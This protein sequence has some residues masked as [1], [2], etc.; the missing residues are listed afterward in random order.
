MEKQERA[1][2]FHNQGYNCCQ[3]V[4]LAFA[5]EL[6]L[7]QE[8]AFRISEGFGLGMGSMQ[9]TCG[10]LSGAMML[11][12]LKNSDANLAHPGSKHDTYQLC[13]KITE[14]FQKK[15]G[16]LLCKD[17]KGVETGTVLCSCQDCIRTGVETAEDVLDL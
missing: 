15:T 6:G 2:E 7:D 9:N 5:E 4:L 10:A 11:A 16:A 14:E 3:S 13:R 1:I 12:G 8:T 17:L